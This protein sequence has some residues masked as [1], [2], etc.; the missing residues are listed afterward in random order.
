MLKPHAA[1]LKNLININ[2]F[3]LE[4]IWRRLGIKPRAA[5]YRSK[6]ANH[7][8][9]LPNLRTVLYYITAISSTAATTQN[10]GESWHLSTLA[11]M[12]NKQSQI[13]I[14]VLFFEL[15]I[16]DGGVNEKLS[17]ISCL[18]CSGSLTIAQAHSSQ[19]T[20]LLRNL[21]NLGSVP[22]KKLH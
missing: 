12:T 15:I 19:K 8:A 20:D 7:C 16:S 18:A 14:F 11:L 13:C 5:G 22:Q 6:Y 9:T 1:P 4:K 2:N 21:K 3:T 10:Y 17:F